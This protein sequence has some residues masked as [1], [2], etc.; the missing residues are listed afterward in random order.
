MRVYIQAAVVGCVLVAVFTAAFWQEH[1]QAEQFRRECSALG[2][3]PVH[4]TRELVCL[5]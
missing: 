4:N 2:G 1:T 3:T 5:H